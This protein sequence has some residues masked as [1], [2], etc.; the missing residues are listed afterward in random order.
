[1]LVFVCECVR[2]TIIIYSSEIM[3]HNSIIYFP[4][5]T[6]KLYAYYIYNIRIYIG[7]CKYSNSKFDNNNTECVK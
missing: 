1:M 6:I 7:D 4:L 5:V 2:V 3:K